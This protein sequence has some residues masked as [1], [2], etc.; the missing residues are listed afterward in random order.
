[1]FLECLSLGLHGMFIKWD[2]MQCYFREKL[3][4]AVYVRA[5][6]F[7][8]GGERSDISF[9]TAN[10]GTPGLNVHNLSYRSHAV[11]IETFLTHSPLYIAF[12][13]YCL[14]P[15]VQSSPFPSP[16]SPLKLSCS[17]VC[18]SEFRLLSRSS[19][20]FFGSFVF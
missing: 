18:F 10:F 20:I 6:R 9:D 2:R 15:F 5:L 14:L 7:I 12:P 3:V 16:P 8:R 4:P 19:V 11:L 1:M 13:P 17:P